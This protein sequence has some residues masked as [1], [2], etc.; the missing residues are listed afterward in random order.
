M[1]AIE[2]YPGLVVKKG[3]NH[4]TIQSVEIKNLNTFAIAIG[5]RGIPEEILVQ[6][7]TRLKNQEVSEPTGQALLEH[8]H[9]C[10]GTGPYAGATAQ[11]IRDYI[12][13]RRAA[14]GVKWIS[15]TR[16]IKVISGN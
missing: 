16:T 7:S 4:Y 2:A 6:R 11:T 8:I 5:P 13:R 12:N 3:G 14:C 15:A 10:Y 9:N 1:K